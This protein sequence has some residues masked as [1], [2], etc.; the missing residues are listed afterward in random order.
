MSIEKKELS[1]IF[2]ILLNPE[3]SEDQRFRKFCELYYNP[4]ARKSEIFRDIELNLYSRWALILDIFP[5]CRRKI[6]DKLIHS[7]NNYDIVHIEKFLNFCKIACTDNRI[8]WIP[9]I[10]NNEKLLLLLFSFE[11]FINNFCEEN[12]NISDKDFQVFIGTN[13]SRIY[14]EFECII[15]EY[16]KGTITMLFS[17][18]YESPDEIFNK[19]GYYPR[20]SDINFLSSRYYVT[21]SGAIRQRTR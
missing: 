18:F 12:N 19:S 16:N 1:D 8:S 11:Q 2:N 4:K 15:K 13:I 20:N 5:G 14:N 3:Y 7:K 9:S 10:K 6:S 21:D 17:R